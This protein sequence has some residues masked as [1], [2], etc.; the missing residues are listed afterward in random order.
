MSSGYRPP[1][2]GQAE[3]VRQ[4]LEPRPPVH[5]LSLLLVIDDLL[6]TV[7]GSIPVGTGLEV[8]FKTVNVSILWMSGG[9]EFQRRGGGIATEGSPW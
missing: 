9:K 5:L 7:R 3:R 1:C 8:G 4:V 6:L 2:S